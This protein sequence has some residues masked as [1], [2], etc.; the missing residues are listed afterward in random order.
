MPFPDRSSTSRS[1]TPA[2]PP[3]ETDA[4]RWKALIDEMVRYTHE[5]IFC[6]TYTKLSCTSK[7]ISARFAECGNAVGIKIRF[8]VDFALKSRASEIA[9]QKRVR[10]LHGVGKRNDC[11]GADYKRAEVKLYFAR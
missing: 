10:C 1:G 7:Y 11:R 2:P 6:I 5:K 8:K 4:D 3:S 9:L